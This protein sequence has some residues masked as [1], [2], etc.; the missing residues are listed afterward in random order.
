M[1]GLYRLMGLF[2]IVIC[3]VFTSACA[4]GSK[5]ADWSELIRDAEPEFELGKCGPQLK[6]NKTLV[7]YEKADVEATLV[8]R[9]HCKDKSDEEEKPDDS[10]AAPQ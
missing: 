6:W 7:V 1:K 10:G 3:L 2:P 9:P 8:I 5:T 4:T